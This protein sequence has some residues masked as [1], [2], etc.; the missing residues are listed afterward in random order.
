V[1]LGLGIIFFTE[2]AAKSYINTSVMKKK[3]WYII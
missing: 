2:F 3:M 1:I